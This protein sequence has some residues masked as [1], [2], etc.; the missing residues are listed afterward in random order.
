M[1]V[2]KESDEDKEPNTPAISSEA[3]DD[4]LINLYRGEVQRVN[5][6][7]NRLDVTPRWAIVLAAGMITWAFSG[8]HRTPYL[9]LIATPLIAALMVL[10]SRRYQM[11]EIWRSRLRLLEENFFAD[12]LDPQTSLPR[13]EWMAVLA[14]DLRVPRHKS[15]L[16]RSI[17]VRLRRIYLWIFLTVFFSWGLK[18]ILHPTQA[19]SVEVVLRRARIGGVPGPV[20][21]ALFCMVIASLV[22]WTAWGRWEEKEGSEGEIPEEEPGYEWRREEEEKTS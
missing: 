22:F 5:T 4:A 14:Q 1:T 16:T 8:P 13:K 3:V 17:A 18:L 21:F 2:E 12:L 19:E 7:R 10:E 20:I 9:I 6:W 15:T 11:H